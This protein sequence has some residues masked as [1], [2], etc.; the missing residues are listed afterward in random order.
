MILAGIGLISIPGGVV[1]GILFLLIACLFL[2]PIRKFFY[3]RTGK[4]LSL[5]K[6]IGISVL[7][8][9]LAAALMP[10]VENKNSNTDIPQ[11]STSFQP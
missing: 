7:I 3:R 10:A 4:T 2:P 1:A 6:R 5:G 11:T 8:F 9:I